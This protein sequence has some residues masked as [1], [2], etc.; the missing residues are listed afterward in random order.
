MKTEAIESLIR[1]GWSLN[2]EGVSRAGELADDAHA[3]LEALKDEQALH[4][5]LIE[6]QHERVLKADKAW[7]KAHNKPHT[8]PDLG[9]LIEWLMGPECPI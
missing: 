4:N 7:Q 3:E 2:P 8:F 9:E 5:R 6:L 1:W